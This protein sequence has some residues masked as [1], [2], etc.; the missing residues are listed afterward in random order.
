MT[1]SEAARVAGIPQ[2]T[3]IA[4]DR[5]GVL[6]AARP[7]ASQR[8]PRHYDEEAL[9]AALFAGWASRMG[10]K[11][12]QLRTMIALVQQGKRAPLEAAAIFTYQSIPGLMTHIFT[13]DSDADDDRRW[14]EHLRD[15]ELLI[16]G[17]ASLWT[18]REHLKPMARALLRTG[19]ARMAEQITGGRR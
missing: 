13:T 16:D 5:D 12:D 2:Q 6:K 8:G 9:T 14:I 1:T 15:Q 4:W 10:F 17:P 7:R 3:L 19:D 11:G 18:I